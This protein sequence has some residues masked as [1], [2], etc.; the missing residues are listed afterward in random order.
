MR[1]P[2][3]TYKAIP[4][5]FLALTAFFPAATAQWKLE[6][7]QHGEKS[8]M[9]YSFKE[10]IMANAAIMSYYSKLISEGYLDTQIDTQS[11]GNKILAHVKKG[12]RYVFQSMVFTDSDSSK[13]II[14]EEYF[15]KQK[16]FDP[17]LVQSQISKTII[18]FENKGFPFA[19]ISVDSISV[20]NEKVD[21]QLSIDR[22]PQLF[23]DSLVIRSEDKFPRRYLSSYLD[24]KKGEYYNESKLKGIDRKLREIPFVQLHTP[25]EI[26][27]KPEKA[28]VFL[29]LK[30]KK[31]NYFNG[32]LGVQPSDATGKIN[33]TGDAEIK[34]LNAF[35]RGEEFYF[36][37]KKLQTQTQELTIKTAHP[38]LFSTPIGIDALLKIYKRDTSYTT[39][40]I[41]GGIVFNFSGTNH[42]RAFVERNN[43]SHMKTYFSAMPLAN[44]NSTI[45]GLGGNFDNL[46]YRFNPRK[47]VNINIQA[48]TGIREVNKR[49]S[50][51]NNDVLKGRYNLYRFESSSEFFIPTFKRQTLRFGASGNTILSDAIYDNEMYRIGGLHTIRGMD[52]ESIYS[53]SWAVGSI[54]YRFLMEENAALYAFFDQG[55]YEKK[56]VGDFTT[57]TPIGFGVGVNFETEAGIFTFNYALGQQFDNP[58]KVRNAKISFG[59][60]SIF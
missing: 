43:S 16:S 45:Y 35:N 6:I 49:L 29:F 53:T 40:K 32:I 30:K 13:R 14:S 5:L 38:F 1:T 48:A 18:Q 34:L 20:Q 47:G 8:E 11:I 17:Y 39:F 56:G 51:A 33:I 41:S 21:I 15:R 4:L 60:R 37:W 22:G 31:A 58:V 24:I 27:F 28:D 54:E 36:N 52:E 46:D 9:K 59:F 3:F 57:D 50:S 10:K 2:K 55:W 7:T 26:L 44:T 12:E 42:L 23:I 19:I 25:S